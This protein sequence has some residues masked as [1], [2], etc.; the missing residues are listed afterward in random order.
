MHKGDQGVGSRSNTADDSSNLSNSWVSTGE[1]QRIAGPSSGAARA[2]PSG[3]RGMSN[4]PATP[5]P[6]YDFKT[7]P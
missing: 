3:P 7:S 1:D 6:A 5:A 2:G 4:I